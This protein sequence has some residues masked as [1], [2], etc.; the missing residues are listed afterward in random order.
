[1]CGDAPIAR[2][3]YDLDGFRSK[4]GEVTGCGEI[5]LPPLALKEVFGR[6]DLQLR[7]DEGRLLKLRF[8]EKR[9]SSDVRAAHV[10][11]VG[12]LPAAADWRRGSGRNTRPLLGL[13]QSP[14]R[15]GARAAASPAFS[16]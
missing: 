13:D 15:S 16:H 7:T 11:L 5:R 4:A 1:M 9:L 2:T 8:S 10:D 3:E 6:N 14:E 12:E